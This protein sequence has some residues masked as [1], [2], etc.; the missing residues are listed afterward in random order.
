ME[1]EKCLV[2]LD[3]IL[4]YLPNE[5]LSK[6]P[7]EI[8]E[9]IKQ[10][11][12]TNYKWNYDESKELSEQKINR[13]TIIMLSY[14][15]MEFLLDAEQRKIMDKLHKYNEKKSEKEKLEKYNP[16]NVFKVNNED[17]KLHSFTLVKVEEKKWYQRLFRFFKKF[18][19]R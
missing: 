16:N 18:S 9:N 8:R 17:N 15:N 1:Y 13:Q 2:E 5:Y 6:I 19:K 11:K 14:L 12:D 7:Y 10:K 3:E 4:R